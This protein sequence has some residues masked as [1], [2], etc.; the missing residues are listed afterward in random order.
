MAQ[1][2]CKPS[3]NMGQDFP[4]QFMSLSSKTRKMRQS[5]F[6]ASTSL[7]ETTVDFHTYSGLLYPTFTHNTPILTRTIPHFN[8]LYII[9]RLCKEFCII[10]SLKLRIT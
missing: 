7:A 3:S 10:N 5:E 6:S 9:N 1:F 4:N 8:P 2:K